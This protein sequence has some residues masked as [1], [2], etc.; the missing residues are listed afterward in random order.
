MGSIYF[1]L[2]SDIKIGESILLNFLEEVSSLKI[3]RPLVICDE[4]L[5]SGDYFTKIKPQIDEYS[6][7]GFFRSLSLKGE[8]SYEL[9]S[10]L[11]E[12][13]DISNIDGVVSIGGGSTI[14]IGKGISLLAK[15]PCEPKKLKGFPVDL[16]EPL[17]HITIPSILGSGSEASFNAVFVDEAEGRKLGINYINNF[18]S[19]VLVDPNLTMSAP[20]PSVIASALD[21]MVHCVD[22]FGSIKSSPVSRMFSIEGFKNVW[23]F[24]TDGDIYSPTSRI[25]LAL[26]SIHGIYALM[27]SGDGPTNGFAYYF[28]V[29]DRIPHGMAGG[30]FLKDVML[31]NYKQGYMGY[32]NLIQ[33]S[34]TP[35]I[36]IFFKKFSG[37]LEKYSIPTLKDYGYTVDDCA[38]LSVEVGSALVGSFSGNPLI[39]NEE[40]A[41]WVLDQQFI[42]RN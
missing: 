10:S 34:N 11:M 12:E 1:R 39:F 13:I 36:D 18:P 29:K 15:N 17:P 21:S 37:I 8:P 40:S 31:W 24:L 3:S 25:K 38:N 14:D 27:N 19:L 20:L 7:K 35:D 28:G 5:I 26:A 42:K 6:K 2:R 33:N 41:N 9:L 4:N 23:D 30:M 32:K 16:D 22:S